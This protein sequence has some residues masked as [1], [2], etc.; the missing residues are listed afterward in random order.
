MSFGFGILVIA[1]IVGPL[2]GGH[3]NC[4]V[5][6]GLLIA[7]R[8]SCVKFVFYTLFQMV[9]SVFGALCLWAIFGNDWPAAKA[10]GSNSWDPT[11]FNAGN[12]WFAEVL[13]TM[14]L[15][16]NVLSTVDIPAPGG[17]PLGIYPIAM[18][19]MVAHLFLLPIDGCSINP[20]R[21]FGPALVAGFAGIQGTYSS[22]QYMFWIGPMMGAA[23]A[24]IIYGNVVTFSLVIYAYVMTYCPLLCYDIEYGSL[25]PKRFDGAGD[26]R[27]AIYNADARRGEDANPKKKHPSPL[28]SDEDMEVI[29]CTNMN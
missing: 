16:F 7:G 11:V 26:M 25:K 3:I 8:I 17:G 1:Q 23:F 19:V 21:S 10:F 22:Q 15:V 5:S 12:V 28:V 14:L 27:T 4:A 18:S 29:P 13:G 20:T 9:G 24:A 6:F 2:S